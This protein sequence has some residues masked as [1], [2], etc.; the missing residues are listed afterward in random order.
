MTRESNNLWPDKYVNKD[1][2]KEYKPHNE[3]ERLF[4]FQDSPRYALLKG[5]EGGGKSVAGIVKTLNR[6][7]RGMDG[8]MASPD[9]EHFKKSLWP[10]FSRWCPW[11]CVIERHRYRASPG[12][13]PAGPFVMTFVNEVDGHS[14]L[15][16]GGAKETE[17]EG[18][19][20]QN[21]S[22]A[23]VDEIRRH[24]TPAAV[25]V[26]AGRCRIPGPNG[27]PPQVYFTTTPRKHW[28][29]EYFGGIEQNQLKDVKN[30]D[31]L[32]DF[33]REAFCGTVPVHLNL[34]NLD[35]AYIK[36]RA[37]S[38]TS[39]ER[40]VLM[41]AEWEEEE[42]VAKFINI[43]WW[44]ACAEP[45]RA[46][47]KTEPTV[48]GVDAATG[49]ATAT[50]DCFAVVAVTR[51][52]DDR[53]KVLVRYCGIWQPPPH[54][55]L[56]FTGPLSEIERICHDF[57]V[58]EVCYDPLQLH[59]AMSELRKKG[60]NAK[61]FPQGQP[62][63]VAD[64]NLQSLIMSRRVI[65]SGDVS[66]RSHIDNADFKKY[67]EDGIRIVKRSDSQKVDACVALSMSIN[68]LMYFNV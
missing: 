51:H 61:K 39:K 68:R 49:G 13:Q 65:H 3:D 44:D 42:D 57:A 6:L 26:F 31:P 29:F 2:G 14:N 16:C 47:F 19:E 10:E 54:K 7:R 46:W 52:P 45:T 67:G 37:L 15:Y 40:R 38:L 66:L 23:H 32:I 24:K 55:E 59:L 60:I 28:L 12:W 18:W 43:M 17:I 53:E 56:D 36:H 34:E 33:K 4:V 35:P 21:L 58:V 25:K 11:E 22:F 5:G 27:E 62:R 30:D 9:H 50:A 64:R 8:A 20:G 63:L 41:D 48:I 1:T